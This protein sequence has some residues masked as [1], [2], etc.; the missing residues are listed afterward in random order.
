MIFYTF[1]D[2]KKDVRG[3]LELTIPEVLHEDIDKAMKLVPLFRH[4]LLGYLHGFDFEVRRV[5]L[6]AIVYMYGTDDQIA[7]LSVA[8]DEDEE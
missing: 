2:F 4:Y 8:D 3:E 1:G 7:S 5:A 6:K